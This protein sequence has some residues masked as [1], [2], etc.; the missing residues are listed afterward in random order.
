M[1]SCSLARLARPAWA[2]PQLLV[3]ISRGIPPASGAILA[4][5]SSAR[6][7]ED[8]TAAAVAAQTAVA[9]VPIAAVVRPVRD[10]NAG[11]VAL[12]DLDMIAVIAATLVRRAVRSSSR[13]C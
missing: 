5:V 11:P 12:A 10:S 3:K 2:E 1:S 4:R 13:K 9:D 6:N 8:E 7:G